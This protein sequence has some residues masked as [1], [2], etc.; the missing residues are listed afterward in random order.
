MSMG[1]VS[2]TR[3]SVSSEAR[4]RS[5]HSDIAASPYTNVLVIESAADYTHLLNARTE[6][7]SA[8]D[9][10]KRI[11]P[12]RP[13]PP[14]GRRLYRR[15]RKDQDLRAI[16]A[17]AAP[18]RHSRGAPCRG[19]RWPAAVLYGRRPLVLPKIPA[20]ADR[21]RFR[22][23]ALQEKPAAAWQRHLGPRLAMP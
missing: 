18:W 23:V 22:R 9:S 2:T 8:M 12:W 20:E 6:A 11:N 17:P 15:A 4:G 21:R 19:R 1:N 16:P 13:C 3:R 7:D 5:T 10:F 14:T